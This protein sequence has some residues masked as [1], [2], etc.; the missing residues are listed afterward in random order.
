MLTHLSPPQL[1]QKLEECGW[2]DQ[3]KVACREVVKERGLD[4]VSV[5]E[6]VQE[7]APQGSRLVPEE[8][9]KEL[10]REIK[11]FLEEQAED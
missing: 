2:R 11:R 5:E 9:K 3:V 4:Q 10:L 8:V 6:L 1:A 7:V